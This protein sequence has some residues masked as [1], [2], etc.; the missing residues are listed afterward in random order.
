[1]ANSGNGG[2]TAPGSCAVAPVNLKT[3]AASANPARRGSEPPRTRVLF[4]STTRTDLKVEAEFDTQAQA[5]SLHE[6]LDAAHE[7]SGVLSHR[8]L[9]V[10]EKVMEC[11][12][13][14]SEHA[15]DIS[16]LKVG[17]EEMA[18]RL[19][20]VT[21]FNRYAWVAEPP[22]SI[23][24][25]STRRNLVMGNFYSALVASLPAAS[26]WSTEQLRAARLVVRSATTR[27]ETF[28]R[29][30]SRLQ[31][32]THPRSLGGPSEANLDGTLTDTEGVDLDQLR[33]SVP[34]I[35]PVFIDKSLRSN[36]TYRDVT[37]ED[38]TWPKT[39]DTILSS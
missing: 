13:T 1:M 34:L 22:Q 4:L 25:Y 6:V 10:K 21:P 23:A 16:E 2:N 17:M 20:I 37:A 30:G 3:K 14:M 18:A 11:T 8:I 9:K 26:S 5:T 39:F 33:E 32:A 7:E 28:W 15:A 35:G 38:M 29:S 31:P 24:E 12:G 27:S 36:G 19:L